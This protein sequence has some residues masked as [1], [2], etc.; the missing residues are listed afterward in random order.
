[1]TISKEGKARWVYRC[2]MCGVVRYAPDQLRILEAQNRHQRT[3]KHERVVIAKAFEP[4]KEVVGEIVNAYAT[5]AR[6][7]IDSVKPAMEQFQSDY[8]LTP[9]RNLP[10]DPAQRRDKRTWGGK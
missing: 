4:F 10:H 2:E 9:P 5:M 8:A 7:I 6:I 3:P 1:M